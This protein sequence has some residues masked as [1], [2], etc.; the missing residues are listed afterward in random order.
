M[1]NS[2]HVVGKVF[3]VV[4]TCFLMPFYLFM[5]IFWD[6]SSPFIYQPQGRSVETSVASSFTRSTSFQRPTQKSAFTLFLTYFTFPINRCL[7][8]LF[9]NLIY[10]GLL[11][12]ASLV[13]ESE[14]DQDGMGMRIT[15]SM[16]LRLIIMLI[17]FAYL[18]RLFEFRG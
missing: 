12:A 3:Y 2:T 14:E 15:G 5:R 11:I 16:Y 18:V 17:S 8:S 10:C 13:E 4:I 7:A 1:W 6:M 9:F